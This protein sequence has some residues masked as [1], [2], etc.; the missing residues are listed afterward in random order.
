MTKN[1]EW[2]LYE[3]ELRRLSVSIPLRWFVQE[4]EEQIEIQSELEDVSVIISSF[5]KTD[6]GSID[7]VVQLQRFLD[8]ANPKSRAEINKIDNNKVYAEYRDVDDAMWYV[9]V[10]AKRQ[11][12]LLVTCNTG[13]KP[14]LENFKV[15]REVADSVKIKNSSS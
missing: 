2:G 5:T 15:G 10:Q 13:E 8:S 11:R 12:F 3:S 9:V 6:N 4:I 1:K 7:V 14:S